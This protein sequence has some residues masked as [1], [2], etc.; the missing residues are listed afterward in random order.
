MD[1]K[2]IELDSID[3]LFEYEKHARLIN[4]LSV[5]EL[6]EFAKLYC[7]LYLKQQEVI[8][9]LANFELI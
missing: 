8:K 4:E 3:K 9:N 5:E 7:K 1:N 6:R 2:K